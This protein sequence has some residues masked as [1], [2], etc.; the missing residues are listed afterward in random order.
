MAVAAAVLAATPALAG[1]PANGQVF[2]VVEIGGK[3]IKATLSRIVSAP[4]AGRDACDIELLKELEPYNADPVDPDQQAQAIADIGRQQD[5]LVA[6]MKAV[7]GDL[8]DAQHAKITRLLVE[9]S[10]YNVMRLLNELQS[11]RLEKAFGK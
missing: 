6:A 2:G 10:A 9:L 11:R 3:G 1:C 4:G 7:E 5:N 8:N